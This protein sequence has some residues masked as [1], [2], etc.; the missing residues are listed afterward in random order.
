MPGQQCVELFWRLLGYP[1]ADAREHLIRVWTRDELRGECSSLRADRPVTVA[2]DVQS[3]NGDPC[4]HDAWARE[5]DRPIPVECAARGC[6]LAHASG[7]ACGR[8]R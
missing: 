2:P 8:L 6:A 1:V 7:I 4:S 5:D 3:G